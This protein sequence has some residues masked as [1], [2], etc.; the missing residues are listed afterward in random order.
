MNLIRSVPRLDCAKCGHSSFAGWLI[1]RPENA[2]KFLQSFSSSASLRESLFF[3]SA[4]FFDCI[5]SKRRKFRVRWRTW[6]LSD[7]ILSQFVFPE[8]YG[9]ELLQP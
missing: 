6:V 5:N 7:V 9:A 2:L 8:T 1:K 4:I 3:I